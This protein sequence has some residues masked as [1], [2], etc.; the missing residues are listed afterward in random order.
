MLISEM[1]ISELVMFFV[2]NSPSEHIGSDIYQRCDRGT[3]WRMGWY[4]FGVEH[5]QSN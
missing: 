3:K 5:R 2:S 4:K 1:L